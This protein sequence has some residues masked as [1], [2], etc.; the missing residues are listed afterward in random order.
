LRNENRSG[1]LSFPDFKLYQKTIVVKIVWHSGRKTDL[2][3]RKEYNAEAGAGGN[4][5]KQVGL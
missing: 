1:S 4:S 3:N 2:E 5:W